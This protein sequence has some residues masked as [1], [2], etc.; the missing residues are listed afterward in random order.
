[1]H[2]SPVD[3]VS[4]ARRRLLDAAGLQR[5]IGARG[6]ELVLHGHEHVFRFDQI[7]GVD[8]CVPVFGAPSASR[9]SPNADEMA[10]YYVYDIERSGAGWRIAVESRWFAAASQSFVTRARHVVVGQDGAPSLRLEAVAPCRRS[11]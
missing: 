3:G 5:A 2:H 8:G 6:A 11:A 10:Q 1:M 4:R 9:Q 7:A